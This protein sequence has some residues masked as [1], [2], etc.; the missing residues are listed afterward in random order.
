M[1]R[2]TLL[3]LFIFA[4]LTAFSQTL[5]RISISSGGKATDEVNYVIGETFSFSMADNGNIIV[6]AGTLAGTDNTGGLTHNIPIKQIADFKNIPCYP[7]PATDLICFTLNDKKQT[8]LIITVFDLTGK[9]VMSLNTENIDIMNL[10]LQ[11][12]APGSYIS[13]VQNQQAEVLG[14]FQFIKQ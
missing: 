12:I 13:T 11:G 4:G 6:E 14:S 9:L 5:D 7:N 8:L 2:Q 3:V 10:D 1:R